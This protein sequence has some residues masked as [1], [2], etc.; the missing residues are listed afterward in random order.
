M[1]FA[2]TL[3]KLKHLRLQ[4]DVGCSV[5]A[6]KS[7]VIFIGTGEH[8]DEFEVFET[9]PFVSRLLGELSS[10]WSITLSAFLDGKFFLCVTCRTTMRYF[11]FNCETQCILTCA[12]DVCQILMLGG[13]M[14]T[15]YGGLVRLHG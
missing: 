8:M 12:C 6:T 10:L 3:K 5:A 15:R 2:A 14:V 13:A 11:V 7:P 9:K 1:H 4:F